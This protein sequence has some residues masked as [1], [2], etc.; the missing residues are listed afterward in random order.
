[1]KSGG[2][3]LR[4]IIR[5]MLSLFLAEKEKGN[6]LVGER[7]GVIF[8][9]LCLLLDPEVV[10]LEIGKA[11]E[12]F[13]DSEVATLLTER[14]TMILLTVPEFADLR[15]K[16]LPSEQSATNAG[17]LLARANEAPNANGTAAIGGSDA[18][19]AMEDGRQ[20]FLALYQA[21]RR[22]PVS[23]LALCLLAGE[24]EKSSELVNV[25]AVDMRDKPGEWTL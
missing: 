10:Y 18:A 17:A 3:G 13:E 23:A 14:L 22:Y 6:D 12:D 19:A 1:M 16:L 8:K 21:W 20:L 11:L 9:E 25:V 5:Q 4:G 24:Y 15:R 2:E 7:S